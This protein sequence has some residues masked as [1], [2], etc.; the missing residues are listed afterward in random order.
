MDIVAVI[1]EGKIRE[2]IARGELS[3]L[4]GSG[5]PLEIDD[6]SHVPEELRAGYIM[7]RNAGVL[8]EE[9]QLK[10]EIVT[11]QKLIDCCDEDTQRQCLETKLNQKILR[12]NM[13]MEG[14]RASAALSQYRGQ[15]YRR[16]GG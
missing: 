5:R 4:A 14:R 15:L 1:A 6:L 7:L 2:A 8:P 13:L 3:N 11:L 9:M 12:F 16:L 10:K